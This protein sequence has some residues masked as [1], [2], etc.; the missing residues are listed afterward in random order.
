MT[1]AEFDATVAD[2]A[3]HPANFS[4][5]A[6][7]SFI[8]AWGQSVPFGPHTLQAVPALWGTFWQG[9]VIAPGYTLPALELAFL[10][11]TRL[12]HTFTASSPAQFLDS[13]H[14]ILTR[15]PRGLWLARLPMGGAVCAVFVDDPP[16]STCLWL[17]AEGIAAA[18]RDFFVAQPGFGLSVLKPFSQTIP[19]SPPKQSDHR[20]MLAE[21][22]ADWKSLSG[23]MQQDRLIQFHRLCGRFERPPADILRYWAVFLPHQSPVPPK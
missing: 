2:W 11:A 4:A 13:L 8:R 6:W 9:D 5:S 23:P 18:Y 1:P 21:W 19:S 14:Q 7:L 3:A 20:A 12:E 17:T 15:P 10:R 22:S 16:L